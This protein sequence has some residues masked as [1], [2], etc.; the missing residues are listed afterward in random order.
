MAKLFKVSVAS[1]VKWCQRFRASGS[2]EAKPMG[3]QRPLQLK[4][5][6]EW[7]LARLGGSRT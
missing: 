4:G 6:R 7:I 3:G 2:A 1:V 5:E